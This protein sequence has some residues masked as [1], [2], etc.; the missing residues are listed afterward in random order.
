M[1]LEDYG[2]IGDTYSGALVG[3][4]GSIDWL[5]LPRFDSDACFAAL[6]GDESNGR[7]RI[8]PRE[9]RPGRQSYQDDTLILET[10]FETKTGAVRLI[11]FMPVRDHCRHLV[12]IVEGIRGSVDMKMHLLV[13]FDYGQTVPWVRKVPEGLLAVAGPDALILRSDVP[14]KGENLSTVARFPVAEGE[15][16][17]FVLTWFPAHESVPEAIDV[18]HELE[19][20]RK[21]WHEWASRCDYDG[22][23]RPAVL[24]SLLTLKAMTYAPTGGIMAAITTS[25]PEKLG[26]VRNWDYRFCWLRDATLTLFSLMRSGYTDEAAAWS[27]WLLRAVAGD[28]SQLQIMYGAAGERNLT[29]LEV[30]HLCGYENSKPVRVGNAA[31]EQFQLDVYGEVMGAMHLARE[32]KLETDPANW[33]LQR[34]L[35]EFVAGHWA[36]PDEGIWEIRGPRR[37]FTHSKVMAWV[38]LDRAVR[39]VEEF[40][41]EG[42]LEKWREL[43]QKI[44]E[45]VCAKGYN[46]ARGAFTQ[47]YD[48]ER[49]DASLLMIPLVGFLPATDER[50]VSTVKAIERELVVDGFVL[51]YHPDESAAVD[52]LPPGEGVFLPCSFWLV[53]CLHMTGRKAEARAMF[54]RLLSLRT[55]LGL[56][57]EE[58]D[59]A[60]R[61]LVG[62][63]PQAFSHVSLVNTAHRLSGTGGTSVP[64]SR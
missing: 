53:N 8:A 64:A 50:V 35:V 37:N 38:A 42:E 26:G 25:L 45:D 55:P 43:R 17:T 6:L 11:D 51:R 62:N 19:D 30:P 14:T 58:Y 47:S 18:D 15:R 13:R 56:L 39:A 5:C 61:R 10:Q 33:R 52:G 4:N 12:R 46:P 36:E 9:L 21:Y 40:G 57:S 34:H 1:K 31:A 29:E 59:C 60:A 24:R 28:P 3:H 32:R 27:N 20:T 63:F 54:E 44:H 7:W 48:C 16:K 49:L 23:W 22:E 41:L 2:F